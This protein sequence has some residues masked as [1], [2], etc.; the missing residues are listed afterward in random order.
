M[1]GCAM[2]MWVLTCVL[3]RYL[4][5]C[6]VGWLQRYCWS[7][8]LFNASSSFLNEDCWFTN[9]ERF[10]QYLVCSGRCRWKPICLGDAFKHWRCRW[11]GWLTLVASAVFSSIL[12]RFGGSC[13]AACVMIQD[14]I[15]VLAIYVS[16]TWPMWDC[17]AV[18][19]PCLHIQ[20]LISSSMYSFRYSIYTS[21]I[22]Y[23][24]TFFLIGNCTN[25]SS[26]PV[27]V[28]DRVLVLD[29]VYYTRQV[30]LCCGGQVRPN[31]A[32]T[33]YFPTWIW[34][35]PSIS[36]HF[37]DKNTFI[38][39][40]LQESLWPGWSSKLSSQLQQWRVT[41]Q[42]SFIS[43]LRRVNFIYLVLTQFPPE[44][45]G[46]LSQISHKKTRLVNF[47]VSI[48]HLLWKSPKFQPGGLII[49]MGTNI[50]LLA[51]T[52]AVFNL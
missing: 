25:T 38:A 16:K 21:H 41:R 13:T 46:T 45:R 37:V 15:A 8:L 17:H 32:G 18:D 4:K 44:D 42:R 5:A 34:N 31:R 12:C 33:R 43:E 52:H 39:S 24:Y 50:F 36:K 35:Y 27:L 48:T 2:C 26:T 19:F 30:L 11:F 47:G 14:E 28:L 10:S 51:M 3:Y 23:I 20:I 40:H 49:D 6:S 1:S 22:I 9:Q 7:A 29:I